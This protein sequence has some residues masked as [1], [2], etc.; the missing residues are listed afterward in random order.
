MIDSTVEGTPGS[1]PLLALDGVTLSFGEVTVLDGVTAQLQRG[2][3]TAVVGPNGSGK[4]TLAEVVAGLRRPDEGDLS[5]S[6]TVP[7]L[8]SPIRA[9]VER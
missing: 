7:R 6:A 4:T 1:A 5:L 8:P 9:G 3:V 2:S